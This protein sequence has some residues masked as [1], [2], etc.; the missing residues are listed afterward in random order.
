MLKSVWTCRRA[1]YTGHDG[2]GKPEEATG[3]SFDGEIEFRPA[4]YRLEGVDTW[5]SASMGTGPE[6]TLK[7]NFLLGSYSVIS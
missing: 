6:I 5:K 3:L 7:P 1:S 4:S 2:L